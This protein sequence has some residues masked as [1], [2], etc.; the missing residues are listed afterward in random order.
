M[1]RSPFRS[2]LATAMTM[3]M[4]A[5]LMAASQVCVAAGSDQILAGPSAGQASAT[6]QPSGE[7]GGKGKHQGGPLAIVNEVPQ[8]L[9]DLNLSADQQGK[10]DS[11]LSDFK[12][13]AEAFKSTHKAQLQQLRPGDS[14]QAVGRS[15]ENGGAQDRTSIAHAGRPQ[16]TR[17]VPEHHGRAQR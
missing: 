3:T 10:V 9:S 5:G 13:K 16:A 17:A 4:V 1:T 6:T 11:F 15:L 2:W 12:A 7:M 14:G 8:M